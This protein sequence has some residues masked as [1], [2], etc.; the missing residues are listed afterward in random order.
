MITRTAVR[1]APHPGRLRHVQS[2]PPTVR[3][4][5][6]YPTAQRLAAQL[7]RGTPATSA[8]QA[9]VR[10]LAVQGQDPRGL[11]L[12]VRAR[13][14][15]VTA[16]DVEDAFTE[17]RSL[18]VAWLNRGTLHLVRAAD[19]WWLHPLT[20]PQL[21]TANTLRL[22]RA[23]VSESHAARG[24]DVVAARTIEA[25]P[26]RRAELRAVLDAAGVPT[27]GQALMHLI[28][29]AALRRHLIRGPIVAGEHAYV[30]AESWLGPA[31]Q[32]LDRAE[33]LGRL[34]RRYLAGH[35]PADARDLAVW[36][37]VNLGDARRGLAAIADETTTDADGLIDLTN[38]AAVDDI[39]PPRLL[40]PFDPILHGWASREAILGPHAA[41][42]VTSNGIFRPF[43]MVDGRAVALWRLDGDHVRLTP[44]EPLPDRALQHLEQDAARV[45]DFLGLPP[46]DWRVDAP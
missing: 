2:D 43:A 3:G 42:V 31:P 19:Y 32:P 28:Y 20:T 38:R 18:V 12:A 14:A 23:G 27:A 34:A 26:Q 7:L 1:A 6:G 45:L 46:K 40:G 4:A 17:S 29:A 16:A 13:T 36:G 44:F 41:R 21:A 39:A 10:I 22:R 30:V 33:A 25:G 15:G 5:L 9:V 35:G 24:I 11:R 8:E 37:G